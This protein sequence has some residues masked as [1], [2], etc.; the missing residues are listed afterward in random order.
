MLFLRA[1]FLFTI[2]EQQSHFEI[3]MSIRNFYTFSFAVL[4]LSRIINTKELKG[5][6]FL[7]N[8][9][10]GGFMDTKP[11]DIDDDDAHSRAPLNGT[12]SNN[13]YEFITFTERT[14]CLPHEEA[15]ELRAQRELTDGSG[16]IRAPVKVKCLLGN[17]TNNDT[18]LVIDSLKQVSQLLGPLGNSTKRN[19]P[20]ICGLILFYAKS[21]MSSSMAAPHMNALPK[22]FPDIRVAAIDSFRFHSVNTDFGIIALPTLMLFHHGRPVVKFNE[23]SFTVNNFVKFIARHTDIEPTTSKVYVTSGDFQGP[24]PNTI[25]KDTDHCLWLAWVFIFLCASYHF[26]RSKYCAQIV[27]IVKRNWRESSETHQ[28]LTN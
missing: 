15:S 12:S 23:T 13:F 8:L 3:V 17:G 7:A 18:L 21:C 26:L 27:E 11:R 19:Q 22:Y 14:V 24:L 5:L 10:S 20:G 2:G 25:E 9:L 4:N 1:I 6:E 16:R 28:E